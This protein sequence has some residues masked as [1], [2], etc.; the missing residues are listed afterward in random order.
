MVIGFRKLSLLCVCTL[1]L[2]GSCS[3]PNR[4]SLNIDV[5]S[6]FDND[7]V[8]ILI[9]GKR[10]LKENVQTSH[11]VGVCFIDGTITQTFSFT[12]GNHTIKV[13]LNDSQMISDQFTLNDDLYVGIRFDTETEKLSIEFR[14]EHF[15]YD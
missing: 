12:E 15:T 5:Q 3:E 8:E 14:D 13:I 6:S 1:M 7:D 2:F 10:I 11:N 9:D 4:P